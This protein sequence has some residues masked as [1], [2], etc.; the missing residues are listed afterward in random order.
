M[1]LLTSEVVK[2]REGRSP[3]GFP[4]QPFAIRG[5]EPGQLGWHATEA[6]EKTPGRLSTDEPPDKPVDSPWRSAVVVLPRHSADGNAYKIGEPIPEAEAIRQ[7]VYDPLAVPEKVK[8]KKRA[9]PRCKGTGM[10]SKRRPPNH[11]D[12]CPCR[13]CGSCP[14]CEGERYV[15]DTEPQEA[16][17]ANE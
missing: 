16:L 12:G 10:L 1:P 7:G 17:D 9:C 15:L 14:T 3:G 6:I 11:K 13:F 8:A 5:P 4:P 2:G